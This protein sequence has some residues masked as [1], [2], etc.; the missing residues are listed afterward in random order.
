MAHWDGK[1]SCLGSHLHASLVS[2]EAPP[3]MNS[4][5]LTYKE[6]DT[7]PVSASTDCAGIKG[8]LNRNWN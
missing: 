5:L 3:I 6:Q 7:P 2:M 8:C 1:P 4:V